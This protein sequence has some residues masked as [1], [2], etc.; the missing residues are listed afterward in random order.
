MGNVP[1]ISMRGAFAVSAIAW[2]KRLVFHVLEKQ[3]THGSIVKLLFIWLIK[4][5]HSVYVVCLKV[6]PSSIF[7]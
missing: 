1:D 3:T 4:S 6:Q 5:S 2:A 7:V